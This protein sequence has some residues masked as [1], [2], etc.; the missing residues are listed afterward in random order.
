MRRAAYPRD[1]S[2]AGPFGASTEREQGM[3]DRLKQ[4]VREHKF[5][6]RIQGGEVAELY[7]APQTIDALEA[8]GVATVSE[9]RDRAAADELGDLKGIGAAREAELREA[10]EL[11]DLHELPQDDPQVCADALGY[12]CIRAGE[13]LLSVAALT[14]DLEL[15]I[16]ARD[17]IERLVEAVRAQDD[18]PKT[19]TVRYQEAWELIHA[20]NAQAKEVVA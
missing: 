20:A 2:P 16:H 14:G 6:R 5:A 8:A 15:K 13:R 12:A 18:L 11:Y 1:P 10:L 4:D 7:A 19:G 3:Y 9:L 17:M